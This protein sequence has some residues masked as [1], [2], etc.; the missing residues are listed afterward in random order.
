M[1]RPRSAS[2]LIPGAYCRPARGRMSRCAR[3]V[4]LPK[5]IGPEL[6]PLGVFDFGVAPGGSSHDPVA[7]VHVA[8]CRRAEVWTRGL[9]RPECRPLVRDRS[10]LT[11]YVTPI[12]GALH[13]FG[14]R[15]YQR[16]EATCL[17]RA[18][19]LPDVCRLVDR[20]GLEPATS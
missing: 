14:E 5:L 18:S 6:S 11:L 16:Y 1:T 2:T 13:R 4:R 3:A 12:S 10:W 19:G 17:T 20:A 15:S 7:G 8:G 9:G